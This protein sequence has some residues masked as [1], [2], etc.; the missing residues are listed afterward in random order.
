MTLNLYFDM[1]D[2][3]IQLAPITSLVVESRPIFAKLVQNLFNYHEDMLEIRIYDRYHNQLKSQELVLVTDILSH[4]VNTNTT[5]RMIYNDLEAQISQDPIKKIEIED[6]LGQVLTCINRELVEFDLD[7][8]VTEITLQGAFKAL[9]VKIETSGETIFER[10]F[11]IIQISKYLPQ[12][13]LLAFVNLGT[14]LS[15][16]ELTQVTDYASL[17]KINLLLVDNTSFDVP[18][19]VAKFILDQDFM[20]TKSI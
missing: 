17:Q 15:L 19:E 2:A 13:N 5:L 4:N 14:Y 9:G 16:Q 20:L 7:L 3:P 8:S 10:V 18:K 6:L 11:D 12:K 1:L